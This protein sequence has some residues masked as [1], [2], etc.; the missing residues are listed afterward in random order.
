MQGLLSGIAFATGYGLGVFGMWLWV[1][2]ELQTFEGRPRRIVTLAAAIVCVVIAATYLWSASDWQDSIRELME[3]EPVQTT[4]P[5]KVGAIAVV[6][7]VVLVGVAR[8]FKLTFYAVSRRLDGF[9]PRRVSRVVGF[10]LA[11]VLFI[12]IFNGVIFQAGLDFADAALS[13]LDALQEPGLEKPSDPDKT[14]S[15]VSL[16]EWGSLGRKGRS[17][18]SSG[19]TREDLAAFSGREALDPLR[20]YVGLR[21]ADTV[22][23]RAKLALEELKRVGGFDRST[24]IIATPTGTGWLDAAAVDTVEYL[25]GGDVAIVAMQ[26]SYLFSWLSIFV[27]PGYGTDAARALFAEVYEHWTSLPRGSRPKLYLHGLS[28]GAL[29]SES[30]A[31]LFDVLADPFHGAVWSGPPFPSRFWRSVTDDRHAESPAWLPRF[32]D[33]S[34]VRFTN[35]ENALD[36][37]GATWGP[38]RIVYV[39][40]A[41]DPITFFEV[42]AI[43]RQPEWMDEPRGPD[44]SPAL[45]WYPGVT[46]LQLAGDVIASGTSPMGFG[47]VFAPAHYIDAWLEVTQPPGW[48]EE[49]IVRLKRHFE[50]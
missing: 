32:R 49:D 44:V 12:T 34:L 21:S 5:L 48:T 20:V 41:S 13:E 45:R 30:S 47:H 33:G 11:A 3:L 27:E 22:G 6:I 9:V 46:F 10:T 16:V 8:L 24:L 36:I 39:Q 2:M 15:V 38:V 4:R 43:H 35:Q 17:F 25:H 14:G 19:P 26:Y 18:V 40:Y 1:Y 29:S 28:L 37:A 42:A 31:D 23:A 50:K 7:F